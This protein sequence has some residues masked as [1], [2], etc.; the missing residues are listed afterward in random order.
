M[1]RRPDG[2]H[3]NHI[4]GKITKISGFEGAVTVR[5]ERDFSGK[6]PE[7]ESVFLEIDGRAV[8]F[9]LNILSISRTVPYV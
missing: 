3:E 2:S 4:D 9:F 6:I 7:T 5:P 1:D 8:P